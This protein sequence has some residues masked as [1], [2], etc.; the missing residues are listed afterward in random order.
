MGEL[1]KFRGNATR[2]LATNVARSFNRC[3]ISGAADVATPWI[4]EPLLGHLGHV[5]HVGHLGYFF[6]WSTRIVCEMYI[7]TWV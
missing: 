6:E 5:G 3:A 2:K 1:E 7:F 4:V